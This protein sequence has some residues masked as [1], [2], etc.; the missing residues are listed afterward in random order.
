MNGVFG[1]GY[2]SDYISYDSFWFN[3]IA[4]GYNTT[5]AVSLIPSATDL[6]WIPSAPNMTNVSSSLMIGDYNRSLFIDEVNAPTILLTSDNPNLWVFNVSM[7]F[8]LTNTT[9]GV[10]PTQYYSNMTNDTYNQ[11]LME[12]AYPGMGLAT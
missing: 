9:D 4:Q 11:V 5:M 10:N 2:F 3:M 12:T 6:S 7:G 8:G 1:L